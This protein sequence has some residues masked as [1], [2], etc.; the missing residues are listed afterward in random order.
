M[1]LPATH[2]KHGNEIGSRAHAMVVLSAIFRKLDPLRNWEITWR[3]WK[4][5]RSDAQN[6]ALFGVAYK[7]LAAET[8]FTKDELHVEFCKKFFGTVEHA[9][10]GINRPFRTTTRDQHG[11]RDVL[12]WDEFAKFYDAVVDTA[13][14]ADIAIPPPDPN[15]RAKKVAQSVSP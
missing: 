12:P 2:D 13:A 8:G 14:M 9:E 4:P 11:R 3:V 5:S 15:W 1:I 10:L 6:H 7:I